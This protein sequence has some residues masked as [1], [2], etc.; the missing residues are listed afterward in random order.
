MKEL[1]SKQDQI[2][3]FLRTFIED[4]DYP[5]SIRDIQE[6]CSISSTSVVD[7]NLRKLEEKGMIRRDREVS[8]GI[9]VL[10]SKGGR[11]A[12]II[13][14]PVIG[15]IA[16]GQPIPVPSSERWSY[17]AEDTVA[18][19]EDM[20][21]GKTNVFALRVKGKSMIEDLIDDGDIVFL[22]PARAANDGEKV[23]VWLKDRGEVTLKRIYHE[24]NRV[25]LQPANS[26]MQ[27][28]YTS[29]DNVEIQGRFISS[30][31]PSD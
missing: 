15:A 9:E 6:G 4:K 7:Y 3:D 13:E 20:V 1:S 12:R 23:A 27:P 30:I 8:R 19:T 17:D 26:S 24:G 25:R 16:A 18:A 29:P 2:L 5:P 28:I 21:R 10:G 14:I 22:E 11:R 31:R